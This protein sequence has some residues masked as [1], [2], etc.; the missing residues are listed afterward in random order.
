MGRN[1]QGVRLINVSEADSL[2]GLAPVASLN[3]DSDSDEESDE[4]SEASSDS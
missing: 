4:D 2:V 1:T 3:D